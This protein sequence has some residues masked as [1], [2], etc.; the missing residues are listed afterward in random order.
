MA[1]YPK[2]RAASSGASM[3]RTVTGGR[4]HAQLPTGGSTGVFTGSSS[5]STTAVPVGGGG[6]SSPMPRP[7]GMLFGRSK[8]ASWG[9]MSMRGYRGGWGR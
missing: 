6:H 8:V 2:G 7:S 4:G 3:S 1:R 5:P 9:S